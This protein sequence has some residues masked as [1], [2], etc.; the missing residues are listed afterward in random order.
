MIYF[1]LKYVEIFVKVD[2]E[3]RFKF[4]VL[5]ERVFEPCKSFV[6]IKLEKGLDWVG[7]VEKELVKIGT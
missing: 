6:F 2:F 7:V 5:L 3:V 4:T 1:L